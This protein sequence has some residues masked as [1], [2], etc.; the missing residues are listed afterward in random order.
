MSVSLCRVLT[1]TAV[2]AEPA[3]VKT[4]KPFK[5]KVTLT[6]GDTTV[7][8]GLVKVYDGSKLL[9]SGTLAAGKVTIKVTKVLAPGKY[10]LS[11]KY[12][13][14]GTYD[15]SGATFALKVTK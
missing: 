8:G 9:G 7:P 12:A 15:A 10:S 14:T 3:L 5:A 13:G 1:S 2:T 6:A 4:G 11:A